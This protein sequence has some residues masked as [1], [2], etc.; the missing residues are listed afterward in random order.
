MKDGCLGMPV[1][2]KKKKKKS[3]AECIRKL[4]LSN[5]ERASG[6]APLYY[7]TTSL[8]VITFKTLLCPL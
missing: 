1:P 3:M 5:S 6:L 7:T 2:V 8:T 4:W